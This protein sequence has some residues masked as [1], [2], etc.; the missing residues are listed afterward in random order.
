[1]G[2]FEGI[3]TLPPARW[4]LSIYAENRSFNVFNLIEAYQKDIHVEALLDNSSGLVDFSPK[5]SSFTLPYVSMNALHR[6]SF[7]AFDQ[8][9]D[10]LVYRSVQPLASLQG[11]GECSTPIAYSGSTGGEFVDPATGARVPYGPVQFTPA[12]PFL[13]YQAVSGTAVPFFQLNAATGEL[14]TQP[15]TLG[16]Q[17]VAIRV[18]EYRKQGGSW[19]QIGSITRDIAYYTLNGEGNHNP[20][21]TEVKLANASASQSP[22]NVIPVNPGQLVS[23]TLTATDPDAGQTLKLS[24]DVAAIIP[25][26]GFQTLIN[27]QAQ[28]SWQV[29]A[30][31]P[32]GRYSFTVTVRDNSCPVNGS[33]VRTITFLVTDKVL[34]TRSREPLAQPAFPVPFHEQVRFQ[35][36]THK[37][38]AILIVDEL[39]RTVDQL[40]SRADGTVIWRPAATIRPGLYIARTANGQQLQ[41]LIR[42]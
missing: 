40:T 12:F 36:T 37:A 18:D 9:G 25:G 35:L 3:V 21:I 42:Q 1:M 10:S 31:L 23:L 2:V 27:N 11:E 38:Q 19:Q 16:Y 15:I 5:F 22:G 41:R 29:P 28:L 34:A 17:V 6:N 8:D 39:G 7:S 26:A 13:S 24:S 33:E 20:T 32:L 4:T 14:L 30:Q